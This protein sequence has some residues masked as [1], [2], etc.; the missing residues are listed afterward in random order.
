MM[1]RSWLQDTKENFTL[2]EISAP[3]SVYLLSMACFLMTKFSVLHMQQDSQLL[4][5]NQNKH[6]VLME[7]HPSQLLKEKENSS[8]KFQKMD[9]Q[10]ASQY[11]S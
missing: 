1:I 2:L 6:Q 11:H 4:Q 8:F 10:A 7:F 9:S 3:I 5:V